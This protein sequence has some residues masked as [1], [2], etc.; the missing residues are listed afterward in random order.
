MLQPIYSRICHTPQ[1]GGTFQ[2]EHLS[3]VQQLLY[4]CFSQ[5]QSP[6][7]AGQLIGIPERMNEHP[8][9]SVKPLAQKGTQLGMGQNWDTNE[10][11]IF[12]S[13]LVW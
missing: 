5:F 7:F 3:I 1:A 2:H 6:S 12:W 8:P 11:T 4:L 13:C 10:H 9:H